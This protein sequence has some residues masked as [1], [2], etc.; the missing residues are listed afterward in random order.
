MD[1]ASR[2]ELAQRVTAFLLDHHP[3][4]VA[5]ALEGSTAKGED[6]EHSDLEMSAYTEG[7]PDTRYYSI[8]HRDIVIEVGFESTSRAL[9]E[10]RK[11][12]GWWPIRADGWAETLALHDP[13]RWLPR[14]AEAA[15]RLVPEDL[16]LARLGALTALYENL[17]KMRNFAA[18]GERS[19]VRFM[20][21]DL[22]ITAA[23]YLALLNEAYF[24]GVR[25]LLT[26]P[27]EFA[28]L[29]IHF[30]HDYPAL[31]GVEVPADRLLQHAE[32]L[33]RECEAIW[34]HP[35][36]RPW[37]SEDLEGALELGRVPR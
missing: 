12:D 16:P 35:D 10:A 2:M 22:A 32:R 13:D 33:F 1:H 4:V 25:N 23:N 6:R 37:E 5:V 36:R 24:N 19:M 28:S 34:P 18:S 8:I 15:I 20:A 14:L 17:C 31:L 21:S 27:Q 7:E 29:P 11:R 3:S 26:K 9:E 30:W